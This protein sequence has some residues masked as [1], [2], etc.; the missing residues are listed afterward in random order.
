[1][2]LSERGQDSGT[3]LSGLAGESAERNEPEEIR[4][5]G[6]SPDGAAFTVV[7]STRRGDLLPRHR[8]SQVTPPVVHARLPAS[9]RA[10]T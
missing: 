9:K 2:S 7:C 10:S 3:A 6:F 8:W 4:A 1:M 5:F